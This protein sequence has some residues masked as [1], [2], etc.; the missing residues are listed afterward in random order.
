MG[1]GHRCWTLVLLFKWYVL[2]F[3]PSLLEPYVHTDGYMTTPMNRAFAQQA[4]RD[5][6]NAVS[7]PV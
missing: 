4:L 5:R 3:S 6:K 7:A 2:A 1:R